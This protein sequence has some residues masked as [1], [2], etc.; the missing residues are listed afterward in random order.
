V[1]FTDR[2]SP[3]RKRLLQRRLRRMAEGEVEADY[4]I[5]P[6]PPARK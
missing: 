1:L 4:P 3:L 2:V 6:P 5:L